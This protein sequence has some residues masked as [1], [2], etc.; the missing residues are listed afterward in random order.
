MVIVD[1]ISLRDAM[2]SSS[3]GSKME[4]DSILLDLLYQGGRQ[5]E[6]DVSNS[7]AIGIH[8]LSHVALESVYNYNLLSL[9]TGK[10]K[11]AFHPADCPYRKNCPY[12]NQN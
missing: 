4:C 6:F 10:Q 2:P 9:I 8:G 5:T 11:E 3:G 1:P 12:S 7:I